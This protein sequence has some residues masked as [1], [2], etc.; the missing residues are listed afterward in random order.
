MK[1]IGKSVAKLLKIPSVAEK[2]NM[3]ADNTIEG[4][5]DLDAKIEVLKTDI[6]KNIGKSVAELLKK[7]SGAGA[8]KAKIVEDT[9]ESWNKQLDA[10]TEVDDC[11]FAA[12]EAQS[13]PDIQMLEL[14]GKMKFDNPDGGVWKQGWDVQYNQDDFTEQNKLKVFV[15]PHSHVNS[16]ISI[17]LIDFKIIDPT[18]LNCR[19]F[20]LRTTLGGSKHLKNTMK[21]KPDTY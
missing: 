20:L 19:F 2:A 14:Y 12:E 9:V 3:V 7:T 15:V 6:V 11:L 18:F 17:L 8:E 16:F 5:S 21:I 1:N 10:K 4:L 13:K